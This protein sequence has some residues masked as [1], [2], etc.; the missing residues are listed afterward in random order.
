MATVRSEQVL[1]P[2]TFDLIK[3][4]LEQFGYRYIPSQVLEQPYTGRNPGV[5]GIATWWIRY[6]DWV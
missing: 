6:F 2:E 1:A 3:A 4:V 5:T